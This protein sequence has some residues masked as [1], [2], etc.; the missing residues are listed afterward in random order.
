MANYQIELVLRPELV[1]RSSCYPKSKVTRSVFVYSRV[2][3]CNVCCLSLSTTFS[4]PFL[5]F[6]DEFCSFLSASATTL[7]DLYFLGKNYFLEESD[8]P[9]EK[10]PD[11]ISS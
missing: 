4:K 1:L 8:Y 10:L 2:C 11:K 7:G 5:V 3:L 9:N 6:F